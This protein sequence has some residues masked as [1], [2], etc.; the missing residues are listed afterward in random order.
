MKNKPEGTN[1]RLE[2]AE[3]QISDMKDKV[4]EVTQ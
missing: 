1:S 3:G 2:D 4:V